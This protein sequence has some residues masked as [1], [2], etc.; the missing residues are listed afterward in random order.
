MSIVEAG[1]EGCMCQCWNGRWLRG[2]N[3]TSACLIVG[4]FHFDHSGLAGDWRRSLSAAILPDESC[5]MRY[6]TWKAAVLHRV[7]LSTSS[8]PSMPSRLFAAPCDVCWTALMLSRRFVMASCTCSLGY[9]DIIA[10]TRCGLHAGH[11]RNIASIIIYS[12]SLSTV[13]SPRYYYSIHPHSWFARM[14]AT[15]WLEHASKQCDLLRQRRTAALVF[16]GGKSA[17]K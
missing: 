5:F 6:C 17:K 8:A 1:I 12:R 11:I 2:S 9:A 16:S 15:S 14:K 7:V 3:S 13:L 10:Y 4:S